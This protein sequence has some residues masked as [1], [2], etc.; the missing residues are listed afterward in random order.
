MIDS[1]K[2]TNTFTAFTK[3][4]GIAVKSFAATLASMGIMWLISEAISVLVQLY[5]KLTNKLRDTTNNFNE[6]ESKLKEYQSELDSL[7]DKLSESKKKIAELNE[8]KVNGEITTAQLEELSILQEQTKEYQ[9]QYELIKA[10]TEAQKIATQEAAAELIKYRQKLEDLANS[11]AFKAL[12]IGT[13]I[14][15]FSPLSGGTGALEFITSLGGTKEN[16]VSKFFGG[17]SYYTSGQALVEG[18]TGVSYDDVNSYKTTDEYLKQYEEKQQEQAKLYNSIANPGK[19]K[20]LKDSIFGATDRLNN[21]IKQETDKEQGI[22]GDLSDAV[23]QSNNV[24]NEYGLNEL[25]TKSVK[26]SEDKTIDVEKVAQEYL[27]GQGELSEISSKLMERYEELTSENEYIN[28]SP[29]MKEIFK[30][31]IAKNE[32]E[33]KLIEY[34]T[35]MIDLEQSGSLKIIDY[36]KYKLAQGGINDTTQISAII[37]SEEKWLLA[38]QMFKDGFTFNNIEDF[39]AML[40]AYATAA[41]KAKETAEIEINSSVNPFVKALSASDKYKDYLEKFQVLAEQGNLSPEI[42]SSTEEYSNI[43]EKLGYS[44]NDAAESLKRFFGEL[45]YGNMM[46]GLESSIGGVIEAQFELAQSG[47]LSFDTTK[48]LLKQYPELKDSLQAVT[49][50]YITE[51]SVLQNLIETKLA[52]Y[53]LDMNDLVD[54]ANKVITSQGGQAIAYGLTTDEIIKQI[55][56]QIA[57][58]KTQGLKTKSSSF[59]RLED[60]GKDRFSSNKDSSNPL[61]YFKDNYYYT[62]QKQIDELESL[63]DSIDNSST[64]YENALEIYNAL[65][66]EKEKQANSSSSSS[67]SSTDT[68]KQAFDD[69]LATL[70]H[71]LA[72][73]Q[74]TEAQYYS[75]LDRLNKEYFAN[76]EEYLS[77]YRQYEE[78]VY[79]GLLSLQDKA[80]DSIHNLVELRKDM[81]K[82]MKQKEID[83]IEK[84]IEAEKKKLD[85]INETIDARKEA[86]EL[87]K[88]EKS[89]EEEM[90]EKNKAISD[91]EVQIERLKLDN[92]ASAQKKRRELEEQLTEKKKDLAD[93]IADYEYDKAI[94]ALD[95]EAEAAEKQYEEEEERLQGQIDEIQKYIDDEKLLMQVAINDI[96]GMNNS[97]YE[98]MKNW[99]L[100]TTGEVWKV[101][102]AWKAAKEA[103]ELYNS[104]NQ[105]PEIHEI[106]HENSQNNIATGIPDSGLN[107]IGGN[108]DYYNTNVSPSNNQDN[109]P[110]GYKAMHTIQRGDTLWDLAVKYY[111]DGTQWTKIQQ[112][113]GGIDP[114][115]LQIG[116]QL[117]IPYKKGTKYVPKNTLAL[118]DEEGEELILHANEKGTLRSLTKGSSVIPAEL[119]EHLMEWGELTP[120]SFAQ[121]FKF[122]TPNINIPEFTFKDI[123]PNISI[124]DININGNMGNLT[125]SDLNEFRKGIVNDV[126]ESMQKNRVKAG[127]Y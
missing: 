79:K 53:K 104:V 35:N 28:S 33:L 111:G 102:D 59:V 43:L 22:L 67:S 54:A 3:K 50:G 96:N 12:Q 11:P 88:D 16:A 106:L 68:W 23:E 77:E 63:L 120:E 73:N 72:M 69:Q 36:V 64:N 65:L 117:Y 10:Q 115:T 125:K 55:K 121:D 21:V 91:I 34:A 48:K 114:Y 20:E 7:S 18:V 74:I 8:L 13:K 84:V 5:D 32:E 71:Q 9:V 27:D 60:L 103:L 66:E 25:Y 40:E 58:L 4:A 62:N 116:R 1:G 97:L 123:A 105:V 90:A 49:G 113:N 108:T 61:T 19:T 95:K 100:E 92:S 31:R 37:D 93:Y 6:Q 46:E 41:E 80:L 101:V 42:L 38:A 24:P 94:E 126:Y 98:D 45:N 85:A 110:T 78:E 2:A 127:R 47:K 70:K 30:D 57:L 51:D 83:A 17:I 75:E 89:H 99:A 14:M 122:N 56:A 87:L 109:S 119:T 107:A 86:I 81:I 15:K 118:T 26:I 44:A 112:A 29:M 76:R 124:G 82:D 52:S 39:T